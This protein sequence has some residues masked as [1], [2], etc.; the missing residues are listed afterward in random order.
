MKKFILFLTISCSV[1][2][3]S[4]NKSDK[5]N[6]DKDGLKPEKIFVDVQGMDKN[7]MLEK[8]KDWVKEKTGKSDEIKDDE[9]EKGKKSKKLKFE[10][11]T[12]N[13]ICFTEASEFNCHDV[14]FTI[15][16][17][18]EDDGFSFEPK[19]LSYQT[20]SKNKKTSLN[21][22]SSDFHSNNGNLKVD[23]SKVPSQIESLFNG[24]SKSLF[25]Y[26]IDKEQEDEW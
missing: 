5:F 22:K 10:G 3:F 1:S 17:K 18:F 6:F 12:H 19:K 11:F 20:S 23:Y 2:I 26:L 15:S 7:E 13:A 8:A 9:T 24:L 25:N 16:I 4:Q 21:F 14:E